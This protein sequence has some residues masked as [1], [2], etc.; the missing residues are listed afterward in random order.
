M[1][2]SSSKSSIKLINLSVSDFISFANLRDLSE[3]EEDSIKGRN[4]LKHEYNRDGDSYRSPWSNTYF[5]PSAECTFFP[6]ENL[7]QLEQKANDLF[8]TYVK[9]YYDYA[10]SSVYFNDTDTQGF[11]ACFLV[12]KEMAGEKDIKQGCW[13]AIHVV[14]CNMKEAP[15]VSYRVISTVMVTVEAESKSIGSMDIA[16]SSAK[17]TQETHTLPQNFGTAD[18]DPDMYHLGIIGRM[19]ESNE[20]TLRNNV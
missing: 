18:C 5:P 11:N 9:L 15:K 6:S 3:K 16:G 20:E 2:H 19:I 7:L 12:K 17:S 10:T 1:K 4:F 8:A 13:D 14:A